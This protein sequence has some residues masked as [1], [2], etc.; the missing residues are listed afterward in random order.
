MT[1]QREPEEL[2]E[3]PPPVSEGDYGAEPPESEATFELPVGPEDERPAPPAATE[4]DYGGAHEEGPAYEEG[5]ALNGNPVDL[6]D[7]KQE[8]STVAQSPL[9]IIDPTRWMN[10]LVP[11]RQW[12]V[13]GLIPLHN[14]T[15]LAGDGGL[16]KS[17]LVM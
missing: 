11:D 4:A 8:H 15:L 9:K 14:V 10:Q 5:P 13:P 17:I 3:T 12:L 6:D 7:L 2:F 16:G 1:E